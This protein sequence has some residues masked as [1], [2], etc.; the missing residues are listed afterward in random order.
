MYGLAAAGDLHGFEVA[1]NA[2]SPVIP[3]ELAVVHPQ[4]VRAAVFN[5]IPELVIITAVV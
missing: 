1:L 5:I 2:L 4:S 3:A